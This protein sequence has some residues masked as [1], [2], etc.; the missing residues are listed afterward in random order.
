MWSEGR[1]ACIIYK[2]IILWSNTYC[3]NVKNNNVIIIIFNVQEFI[4]LQGHFLTIFLKDIR[5][6]AKGW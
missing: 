4:S 1:F 2:F 3:V 5:D 6:A